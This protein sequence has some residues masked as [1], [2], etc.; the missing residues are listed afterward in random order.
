MSISRAIRRRGDVF[1][2]A[3]VLV[4]SLIYAYSQSLLLFPR[5]DQWWFLLNTLDYEGLWETVANTYS[6]N[7]TREINP[8]DVVAFRPLLFAV[9]S[10][11][12]ALFGNHLWAY[13]V[14]GIVLHGVNCM[15][16]Y[17][18][19]RLRD[20]DADGWEL[21]RGI[22]CRLMR[23]V[24]F[25]LVLMFAVN[26]RIMELVIWTHL[27]GYL[28]FF[29][30]VLCVMQLLLAALERSRDGWENAGLLFAAWTI[31][32]VASFA[33]EYGQVYA[34]LMGVLF[35]LIARNASFARRVA[36][37]VAAVL[38]PCVFQAVNAV[39]QRAH[40]ETMEVG[41]GIGLNPDFA[42]AEIPPEL[43]AQNA[44]RM[45]KHVSFAPFI[46]YDIFWTTKSGR[47]YIAESSVSTLLTG[48]KWRYGV[49]ALVGVVVL[50]A[51]YG[52]FGSV[53]RLDGREWFILLSV[54]SMYVVYISVIVLFRLNS[55]GVNALGGNSY[56][57]YWPFLL[58]IVLVCIALNSGLSSARYAGGLVA[59][60]AG[61]ST[62][63]FMIGM[64]AAGIQSARLVQHVNTVFAE[65]REEERSLKRQIDAFIK[66]R[67]GAGA[68]SFVFDYDSSDA[69]REPL[70]NGVPWTSI[71]YRTNE[72]RPEPEY[73]LRYD[74]TDLWA[75]DPKPHVSTIPRLVRA[76]EPYNIFAYRDRF[77][78]IL[79]WE[80]FYKPERRD[81][82]YSVRGTTLEETLEKCSIVAEAVLEGIRNGEY[83]VP[84]LKLRGEDPM[85]IVG[86]VEENA[87]R[88][89]KQ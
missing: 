2:F 75:V 89:A 80:G 41:S 88:T 53:R 32:L 10:L 20:E 64:I 54:A 71:F 22:L 63:V 47:V 31:M 55:Q 23:I 7:R 46:P 43:S 44:Y 74:G 33:Y 48:E 3:V 21:D 65:A 39:D 29:A 30:M 27:H 26:A 12:K 84:Y 35:P 8:A 78:G 13:Q 16:V 36:I 83:A 67:G 34:V 73:V 68:V 6:Y 42:L 69:I 57:T 61:F 62:L 86:A 28:L 76:G 38:I 24:P 14:V 66:E 50:L 11:E 4:P 79:F 87:R 51:L 18:L 59:A 81:Y 72:R 52:A 82:H 58:T 15:Q 19:C 5:S 25:V 40:E 37:V 1:W 70:D 77:V 85:F 45:V 9:L 49:L 17:L 60:L 56:Y